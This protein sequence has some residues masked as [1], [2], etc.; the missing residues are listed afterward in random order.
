MILAGRKGSSG[1]IQDKDIQRPT[2][3]P[4]PLLAAQNN[5]VMAVAEAAIL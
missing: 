2:S 5:D 1:N 3:I 4:S